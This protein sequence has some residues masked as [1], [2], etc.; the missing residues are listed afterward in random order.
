MIS[1]RELPNGWTIASV[2]EIATY[3][4]GRAFKPSE[5]RTTGLPIVR[6]QNLNSESAAYNFSA[7]QHESRFKVKHG[8][9]LFAWSASLGAHIWSGQ[10]AWLNQ[11]IFRVDHTR[12]VAR[13]FLYYALT[14]I[15]NTLYTKAHGSGM[16]HVTKGRFEETEFRL[17]PLNEQRRIAAKIDELF[18]ELDKGIESLKTARAQLAIYRQAVLRR[19]FEGKLTAQWREENKG[20][21][22]TSAQLLARIRREREAGYAQ[23]LEEWR[24]A[25]K[26]C[27][28]AGKS[29][30]KRQKPRKLSK[31]TGLP[32]TWPR[33]SRHCRNRGGGQ[34]LGG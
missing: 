30:E 19:A 32:I 31:V 25:V 8:D 22:E 15:T 17:P 21:P 2:G 5:W 1:D 16:V 12:H 23:Q 24:A 14:D 27:E 7:V 10:N 11:H 29:G 26:E 6:I 9:L 3:Q 13:R 28:V 20:T 18:S 4:N 33:G 34:R